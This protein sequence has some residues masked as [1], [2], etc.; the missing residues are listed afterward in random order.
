MTGWGG[1]F[2]A[3]YGATIIGLI[4]LAFV[5]FG[6]EKKIRSSKNCCLKLPQI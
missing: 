5:A 1:T 6:E 3:I 2:T 4:F